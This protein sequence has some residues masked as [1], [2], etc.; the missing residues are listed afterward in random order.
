MKLCL[1]WTAI[2]NRNK[3][4]SRKKRKM[5]SDQDLKLYLRNLNQMVSKFQKKIAVPS[6]SFKFKKIRMLTTHIT[7]WSNI[8]WLK[9]IQLGQVNSN[10]LSCYVHK[11]MK[12]IFLSQKSKSMRPWYIS[13]PSVG[14]YCLH[15]FLL[16]NGAVAGLHFLW[17]W[18]LLE[19]SL[20]LLRKLLLFLDAFS[21]SKKRSLPLHLW[22]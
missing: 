21:D 7:K 8:L 20:R 13:R 16:L 2:K 4:N 10:K 9:R 3:I 11:L 22:P 19:A 12:T 15:V 6:R 1:L 14:N 17:L 18:S 5:S